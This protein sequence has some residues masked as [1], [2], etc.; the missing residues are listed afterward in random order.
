MTA[1][2]AIKNLFSV[3]L[4]LVLF[5]IG[6][7]VAGLGGTCTVV[8]GYVGISALFSGRYANGTMIGLLIISI[9][10]TLA[11]IA[12][13][14]SAGKSIWRIF[15]GIPDKKPPSESELPY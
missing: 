4:N 13:I 15:A 8:N 1:A 3:F 5:A 6:L 10:I 7:S 12:M 14:V 9:P 2:T 11:G